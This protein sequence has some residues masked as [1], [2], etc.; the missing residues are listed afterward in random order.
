M[1]RFA[2]LS[3]FW[4]LGLG[5]VAPVIAGAAAPVSLAVFAPGTTAREAMAYVVAA[6]PGW[7]VLRVTGSARLPV[8]LL[9][10]AAGAAGPIPA[11]LLP[12]VAGACGAS[13]GGA[14]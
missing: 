14:T 2:H 5:A 9:R 4:L 6:G 3:L 12:A 13:P 11:L 10:R 8:L 7:R 1:S